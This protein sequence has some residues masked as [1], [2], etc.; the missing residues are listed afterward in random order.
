M[1][2]EILIVNQATSSRLRGGG[3]ISTQFKHLGGMQNLHIFKGTVTE[4]HVLPSRQ[5]LSKGLYIC[6]SSTVIKSFILK[7]LPKMFINILKKQIND[8]ES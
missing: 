6:H 3:T 4:Q 8:A 7:V 1:K 5:D 2:L